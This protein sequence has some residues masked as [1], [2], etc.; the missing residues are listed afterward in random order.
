[1][2]RRSWLPFLVASLMIWLLSVGSAM[3]ASRCEMS[4]A[5]PC[6]CS[7]SAST[8][9]DREQPA[10][11]RRSC[12]AP[13]EALASTTPVTTAPELE[14]APVPTDLWVRFASAPTVVSRVDLPRPRPPRGPPLYLANRSLLL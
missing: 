10:I 12:C 3:S 14:A 7:R 2:L 5:A 4:A 1:M 6:P 8:P 13:G 11:G 9:Q